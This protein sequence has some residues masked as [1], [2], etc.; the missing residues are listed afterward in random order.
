[1]VFKN[2]G[3]P[4]GLSGIA[5]F[6]ETPEFYL[7]ITTAS[8]NYKFNRVKVI[9]PKN[10]KL[11]QLK[12]NLNEVKAQVHTEIFTN[13][14]L[15]P[16]L[17]NQLYLTPEKTYEKYALNGLILENGNPGILYHSIGV[18]GAK[19]LDYNKYPLFFEQLRALDPDVLIISLGTNEAFDKAAFT[20]ED[21]RNQMDEFFANLKLNQIDI[22]LL[23]TT[24]PPALINKKDINPKVIEF[25]N[26]LIKRSLELNY[27]TWDLYMALGTYDNISNLIK[28]NLLSNDRIHYTE[29][30]YKLQGDFFVE[31]FFDS[32]D[33]YKK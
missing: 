28:N 25:R 33:N 8:D 13:T 15:F 10:Q 2:L 12:E 23:I 5:F 21:F 6:T 22:P 27:A 16:H 4:T 30:G 17:S 26:E 19:F 11:F 3:Y 14:Y 31:A 7:K 29:K 1:M 9:T 18:N 24:P 20:T 32:Y